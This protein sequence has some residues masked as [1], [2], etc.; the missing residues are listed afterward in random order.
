VQLNKMAPLFWA[1][2]HTV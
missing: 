1:T 2:L